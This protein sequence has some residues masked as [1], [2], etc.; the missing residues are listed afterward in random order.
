MIILIQRG[1]LTFIFHPTRPAFN[2]P[3]R[4]SPYHLSQRHIYYLYFRINKITKGKKTDLAKSLFLISRITSPYLLSE[5]NIAAW[6]KI[7]FRRVKCPG[8]PA[9]G[10]CG[11]RMLNEKVPRARS[12]INNRTVFH[13]TANPTVYFPCVYFWNNNPP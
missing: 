3:R 8:G 10:H 4:H 13:E 2:T 7:T 12:E 6:G 1:Y 5:K 11:R 9:R